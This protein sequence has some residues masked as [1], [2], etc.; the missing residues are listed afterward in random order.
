MEKRSACILYGSLTGN[1]KQIADAFAEVLAEYNFAVDMIKIAPNHDWDENPVHTE[2]YDLVALGSPVIAGLPYKEVYTVCGLQGKKYL[3]GYK[4]YMKDREA[5]INNTFGSISNGK[6]IPG[7][8]APA[9]GTGTPGTKG[10][11]SKT[12]YGIAFCTYGGSG[13]GPDECYGT[14]EVIRELLRVNNVRMVGKFACPGKEVRHNSV[15]KISTRFNLVID[16]AQALMQRYKENPDAEEFQKYTPE[17]VAYIKKL[18]SANDAESFSVSMTADND[19]LGCG[20]PGSRMW[21][22]DYNHRPTQRDITKAKIFIAE[23]I[24]DYFLT[25]TGDPRPP[26]SVYTCIS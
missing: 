12:H 11:F 9:V 10:E 3:Y 18:S 23:I 8:V 17:E 5:R 1:T 15:E 2:N 14:L 16:D 21:H 22:Y 4:Q 13:C 20:K 25:E 6:G 24:E 19:P 7:V 26:Y